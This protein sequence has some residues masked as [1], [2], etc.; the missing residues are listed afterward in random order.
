LIL[1]FLFNLNPRIAAGYG[2][3]DD[4]ITEEIN[5]TPNPLQT[6]S[7]DTGESIFLPLVQHPSLISFALSSPR[8]NAPFFDGDVVFTETAIFW[9]GKVSP[10]E[11]Y[12]DVRI[13]YN[14]NELFVHL[15]V[16]DR[17]VWYDKTPS[18]ATYK[19]WD[20]AS[21]Y[22]DLKA[23]GT[24]RFDGQLNNLEPRDA[25]QAS[26]QRSGSSWIPASIPFSTVTGWR[27]EGTNGGTKEDRGWR[28][29]YR[30][31]FTSLGLSA[32]PP[33]GA[34]WNLAVSV[35]DR[36]YAE[37]TSIPEKRWPQEMNPSMPSGWGE[38]AFG[39]PNYTA[40]KAGLTETVVIR[41]GLNGTTVVDGT[42]GGGTDCGDTAAD[43]N[44]FAEWGEANYAGSHQ[45]NVQNQYDVSDWP[46]FSK[47]YFTFPLDK[48]PAGKTILSATLT[49][50]QFSNAGG[51]S[52]G[53][54][55]GSWI[56]VSKVEESWD[57][58]T[59]TWNNAPQAWEN[60]GSTWVD[61]ILSPVPWPGIARAWDVSLA[62][63]EAYSA[64]EPLRLVLYSADSA[65]HSGKYFV[66]SDTGD[67]NELGRPSLEVAVGSP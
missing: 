13:G 52:Y 44:F 20:S 60:I 62:V 31:P 2:P 35:F 53:I 50:Y 47:V 55:P 25:F 63:S 51:G 42:V 12:T 5:P 15:A 21:L 19:E 14:A 1:L 17:A 43:T 36:D 32:P 65:Q 29:T 45:V 41:Q 18:P 67:W 49:V 26:Y 4:P 24:Y 10:S 61:W 3:T 40:A 64:G 38:L 9:F 6:S 57:E 54:P 46:C 28:I 7:Y 30:I 56:Q 66:S 23:A 11:N 16:F 58:A 37:G 48:I 34:T 39:L 22:I 27:G 59:L 8:I 33:D